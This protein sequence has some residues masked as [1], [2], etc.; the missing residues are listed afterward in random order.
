MNNDALLSH[1]FISFSYPEYAIIEIF[2]PLADV[3]DLFDGS[4]LTGDQMAA[5]EQLAILSP[6]SI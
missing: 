4:L 1:E 5:L 3:V 2:D 6:R